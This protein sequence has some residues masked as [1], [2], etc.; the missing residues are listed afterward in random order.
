MLKELVKP[1]LEGEVFAGAVI[2]GRLKSLLVPFA[3]LLLRPSSQEVLNLFFGKSVLLA[4]HPC[5]SRISK[6]SSHL[7]QRL[8]LKILHL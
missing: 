7:P 6:D 2:I 1:F 3:L 5:A 4:E 8:F